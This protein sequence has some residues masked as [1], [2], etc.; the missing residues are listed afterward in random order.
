MDKESIALSSKAMDSLEPALIYIGQLSNQSRHS[1]AMHEGMKILTCSLRVMFTSELGG[2]GG[3]VI[4]VIF[5][6]A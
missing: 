5:T 3:D 4:S 6:V 2:G 1:S